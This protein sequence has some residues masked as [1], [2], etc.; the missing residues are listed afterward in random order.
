[1]LVHRLQ[2]LSKRV[3]S[4]TTH[5]EKHQKQW[6]PWAAP[7]PQILGKGHEFPDHYRLL[8]LLH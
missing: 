7:R 5:R 4:S 2:I 6:I 1:M 3:T 8:L